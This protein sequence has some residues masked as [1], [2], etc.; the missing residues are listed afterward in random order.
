MQIT[1][2]KLLALRLYETKILKQIKG[3]NTLLSTVKFSS[4]NKNLRSRIVFLESELSIN[5]KFRFFL[6]KRLVFVC[7]SE[8]SMR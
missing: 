3:T 6:W 8:N 2:V 7:F 4:R 1:G 5:T